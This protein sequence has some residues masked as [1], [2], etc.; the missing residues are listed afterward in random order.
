MTLP[1]AT[2]L[3]QAQ[4]ITKVEEINQALNELNRTLQEVN[5]DL[6][7]ELAIKSQIRTTR[8]ALEGYEKSLAAW[9]KAIDLLT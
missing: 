1:S 7:A 4:L 3:K 8:I 2:K 6:D 5:G 9:S